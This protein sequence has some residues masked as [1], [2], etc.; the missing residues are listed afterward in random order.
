MVDGQ[1]EAVERLRAKD[2]G[3]TLLRLVDDISRRPGRAPRRSRSI[4]GNSSTPREELEEL[5]LYRPSIY[6]AL[7]RELT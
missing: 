4:S 2:F 3:G 6:K 1:L 5:R 7:P